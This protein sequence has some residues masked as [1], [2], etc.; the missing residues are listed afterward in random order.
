MTVT[1]FPGTVHAGHRATGLFKTHSY[2]RSLKGSRIF[3][4]HGTVQRESRSG[5]REQYVPFRLRRRHALPSD[6]HDLLCLDHQSD[7]LE[8]QTLKR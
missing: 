5:A 3:L 4:V 6:R 8:E 2:A 1:A 7:E